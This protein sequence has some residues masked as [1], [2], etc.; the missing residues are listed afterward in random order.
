[1]SEHTPGT[2]PGIHVQH[3][4]TVESVSIETAGVD[5][6]KPNAIGLMGVIFV[7]VISL[8]AAVAIHRLVERPAMSLRNRLRGYRLYD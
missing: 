2:P 5:R 8:I 7:A 6:L 4:G 1:M 3:V